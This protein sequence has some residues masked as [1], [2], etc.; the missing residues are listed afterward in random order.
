VSKKASDAETTWTCGADLV[1]RNLEVAGAKH[2][3]GIPG[4]KIDRVFDSLVDSS[5]ETVVVRHEANA[6]FMAAAAV[7][8]LTGKA[9][10]ALVTS[11]PSCSNLATGL[12]TANSEGDAMV[13]T[14]GAVKLDNRLKQVLQTMDT[15]A[16][17]KP[18]TKYPAEVV[19]S[20]S[21][22][23]VLSNAF[24]AAE[25]PRP[26]ASFVSLPMDIVNLPASGDPLT[27][28]ASVTLGAAP[29]EAVRAAAKLIKTSCNPVS[30]VGLLASRPE[31]ADVIRRF[32]AQTGVPVVGTYQAAGTIDAANL[33]HF[34]GRVGLWNNQPDDLL[35]EQADVVVTV[36]YSPVEYDPP[37]WNK[38]VHRPLIHVDGCRPMPI[39]TIAVLSSSWA[40]SPWRT[41]G[42]F[43][44]TEVGIARRLPRPSASHREGVAGCR[45]FRYDYVRRHG[46][47]HI[48]IARYLYRFRA[49]QLLISN[50]PWA[51]RCRGRSPHQSYGPAKKSSRYRAMAAS[52]SR[53]WNSRWRCASS[54]TSFM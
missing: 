19:T 2:V 9:G 42:C 43:A 39:G 36:G 23:E 18:I 48:W 51:L 8:R 12:A 45:G 10:V 41:Q 34:V 16:L 33:E 49:R 40:T 28:L 32:V 31:N 3:F 25:R 20:S 17:F 52:C 4:E 13:V 30:L 11:G 54:P 29:V 53:A 7:G 14:G 50:K 46:R 1:V 6:A 38:N 5:I 44:R 15:V 47:F 27:D 26:G 22:S 21:I 35:L 37:L 24:R